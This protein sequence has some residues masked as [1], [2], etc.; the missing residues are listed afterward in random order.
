MVVYRIGAR[1]VAARDIEWIEFVEAAGFTRRVREWEL[2]A[3]LRL[4]QLTLVEHPTGGDVDPGTGG[5]RKI[6]LADP[7]RQQGKRGGIRVH[8]LWVGHRQ[9]IYLLCMY[10][11]GE[12]ASLTK[13]QK[14]ALREV[15]RKIKAAHA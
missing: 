9:R 1:G 2:D 10:R 4:L 6:R 13:D 8:Y 7:L 3:P 11:K 14:A 15:V 5:L 12:Q